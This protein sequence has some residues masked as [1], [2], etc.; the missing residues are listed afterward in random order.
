MLLTKVYGRIWHLVLMKP[1]EY[2]VH[3]MYGKTDWLLYFLILK[4]LPEIDWGFRL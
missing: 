3:A 4:W 2:L 1:R